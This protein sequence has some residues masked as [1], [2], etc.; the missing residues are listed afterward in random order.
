MCPSY[1]TR[2]NSYTN[3]H[4]TPCV[5]VHARISLEV[6]SIHPSA[7]KNKMALRLIFGLYKS[8]SKLHSLYEKPR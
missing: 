5:V 8:F 3:E 7:R 1:V 4:A 2:P 6:S